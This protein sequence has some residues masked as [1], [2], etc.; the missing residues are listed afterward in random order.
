M[1]LFHGIVVII[2]LFA[3]GLLFLQGRHPLHKVSFVPMAGLL[4]LSGILFVI[5]GKIAL[6]I[7]LISLALFFFISKRA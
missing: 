1:K 5:M 7:A 4:A 3:A 6:L 2:V